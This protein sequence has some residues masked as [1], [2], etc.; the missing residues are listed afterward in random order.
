MI[1]RLTNLLAR[2]RRTKE[3][4]AVHSAIKKK[5]RSKYLYLARARRFVRNRHPLPK[6]GAW[7]PA[8]SRTPP[9]HTAMSSMASAIARFSGICRSL[10]APPSRFRLTSLTAPCQKCQKSPL[11]LIGSPHKLAKVARFGAGQSTATMFAHVRPCPAQPFLI[12]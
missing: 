6:L 10:E 7:Q 12:L 3:C 2:A 8:I 1:A 4:P 9:K 5:K 11:E